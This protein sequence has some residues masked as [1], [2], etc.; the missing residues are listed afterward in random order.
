[1]TTSAEGGSVQIALGG[2]VR[3]DASNIAGDDGGG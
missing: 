3:L 1:M 2:D